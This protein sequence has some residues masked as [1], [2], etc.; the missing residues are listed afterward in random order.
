MRALFIVLRLAGAIAAIAAIVVQLIRTYEYWTELGIQN[1]SG[2]FINVS[3]FFTIDSIVG[4]V[5]VFAIGSVCLIRHEGDPRGSL[6]CAP[7]SRA[8]WS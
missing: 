2:D 1:R 5:I 3:S 7:A 8:T 4:A 6:C